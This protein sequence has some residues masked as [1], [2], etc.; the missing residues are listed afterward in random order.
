M[1]SAML[2][3]KLI[4]IKKT[5]QKIL[6][7]KNANSIVEFG[8]YG[9]HSLSEIALYLKKSSN[10]VYGID[11]FEGLPSSEGQWK[12]G[13]FSCSLEEC[14]KAI[15]S[16]VGSERFKSITLIKS[17]FNQLPI[18]LREAIGPC[19]LIHIDCD[20]Y[21][22]TLD[23]LAFSLP[24]IISGTYIVFDEWHSGPEEKAWKEFSTEKK[25]A[26]E[27]ETEVEYQKIIRIK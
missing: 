6:D 8:V 17:Y 11:C 3:C 19:S 14:S 4:T 26:W 5:L 1:K 12:K 16:V 2:E 22:S 20:L 24:L 18:E 9:G 21:Q 15:E 27:D 7:S 25:I 10:K 23:A 13:D